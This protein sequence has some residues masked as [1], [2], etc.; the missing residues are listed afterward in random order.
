MEA[1]RQRKGWAWVALVV[2]YMLVLQSV[3]GAF[4]IGASASPERNDVF[5]TFL[6]APSGDLSGASDDAPVRKHLPDCCLYGCSM[7]APVLL[8][9]PAAAE[10]PFEHSAVLAH[11]LPDLG[12]RPPSRRDGSPGRPRAP[13]HSIAA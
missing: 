10:T 7:F 12:V 9:L 11:P 2:A 3:L 4:A 8:S 13:P 5:G 1:L 6:C